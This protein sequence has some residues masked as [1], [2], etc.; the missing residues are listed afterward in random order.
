VA[1]FCY[2]FASSIY[3]NVYKH[4]TNEASI[5]IFSTS[6]A[7]FFLHEKKGSWCKKQS[8]EDTTGTSI[9]DV[10]RKDDQKERQEYAQ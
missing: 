7:L 6:F 5:N 8:V 2:Y 4:N 3:L 1:L 9:N 10:N